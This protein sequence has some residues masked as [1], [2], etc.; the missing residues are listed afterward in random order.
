M[1]TF[2]LLAYLAPL[3]ALAVFAFTPPG[4]VV[5]A[6]VTG[7]R[8]GR[9]LA[10][11]AALA[12]AAFVAWSATYRAGR[13]AGSAGALRDVEQ[14]NAAAAERHVRIE[15]KVAK[16]RPD[17][18]RD[19]LKRWAPVILV[20]LILGGCATVPTGGPGRGGAW[21]DIERPIRLSPERV[22]AMSDAEVKAAIVHNRHGAAE[23][24][25]KPPEKKS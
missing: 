19:E 18:L 20:A 21:C 11:A 13:R 16:A 8:L 5:V 22:D 3:I 1:S 2:E 24:G 15:A 25:W 9:W 17:A 23:C 12:Y 6:L 7:T 14:A 10:V 4:R